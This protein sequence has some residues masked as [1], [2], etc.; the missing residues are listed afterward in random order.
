[1]YPTKPENE[2]PSVDEVKDRY[3]YAQ[4]VEAARCMNEGVLLAK[5]DA[6]GRRAAQAGSERS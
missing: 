1:M 3:L 6:Q 2:Q 5:E 4:A